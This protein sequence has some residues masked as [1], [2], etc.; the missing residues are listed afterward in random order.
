MLK[1]PANIH[2]FPSKSSLLY[3]NL[4]LYSVPF[5][6]YGPLF[7]LDPV[8]K[9]RR[10]KIIF[11]RALSLCSLPIQYEVQTILNP[12][13]FFKLL[14][15]STSL[16]PL[17]ISLIH[18]SRLNYTI[19]QLVYLQNTHNGLLRCKLDFVFLPFRY[20]RRTAKNLSFYDQRPQRSGR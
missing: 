5:S 10:L 9:D 14:S 7:S 18:F 12:N 8:A 20:N 11:N 3:F 4:L 6:A 15:I 19:A 16:L 1:K 13:L 2:V 17:S